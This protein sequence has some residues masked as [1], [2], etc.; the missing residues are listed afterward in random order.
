[1]F[2]DVGSYACLH[3]VV[4]E[5]VCDSPANHRIVGSNGVRDDVFRLP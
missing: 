3:I 2:M 5:I 1:M 4:G